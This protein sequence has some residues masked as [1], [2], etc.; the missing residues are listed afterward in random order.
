VSADPFKKLFESADPTRGVSSREID[1]LIDEAQIFQRLH[2]RVKDISRKPQP[3]GPWRR[4]ALIS[5]VAVLVL[6]GAAAAITLLRSPVTNT[7]QVSCY[8]QDSV[9][10]KIISEVPYGPH[11]LASCQ[12]QLRWKSVPSSPTPAGL[13]CVLPNGTLGGFPPSKKF[14]NCSLIGLA[15]FNGKLAY[16]HVLAFEIAAHTYFEEHACSKVPSAKHEMLA[17]IGKYGLRGWTIHVDG[18][19]APS[20]CATL[21]VQPDRHSVDVVGVVEKSN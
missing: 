10:S 17:L 3:H 5:T 8:S 19:R 6:G 12:A 18:L 14:Q 4:V 21:A 15:T 9:H 20:A 1:K 13:L 16:P 7:S 2:D 11:P